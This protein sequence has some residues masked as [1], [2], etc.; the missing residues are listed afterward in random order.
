MSG[1]LAHRAESAI[2]V[3]PPRWGT[4]T[5]AATLAVRRVLL[6]AEDEFPSD[7]DLSL[8]GW[9]ARVQ[10]TIGVA[11]RVTLERIEQGRILVLEDVATEEAGLFA[12]VCAEAIRAAARAWGGNPLAASEEIF[13]FLAR[14]EASGNR[15][16]WDE[17]LE[18][19]ARC[20]A[21]LEPVSNRLRDGDVPMTAVVDSDDA[22]MQG[23]LGV[24]RQAFD[25]VYALCA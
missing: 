14:T 19:L 10:E 12:D 7:P 3:A 16:G 6:R 2:D 20:G 13:D 5:E 8:G 17:I 23:L 22:V 25:V 24:A 11:S 4:R 21:A 9:F 18:T 15:P 1:S